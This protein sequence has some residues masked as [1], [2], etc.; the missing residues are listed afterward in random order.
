MI[1]YVR[2]YRRLEQALA[3]IEESATVHERLS[4]I[5]N[6]IVDGPGPDLGI[7]G[8]RLYRLDEVRQAVVLIASAGPQAI[9]PGFA[10]PAHYEPIKRLLEG[11]GFLLME[12]DDPGFDTN[13]EAQVGVERFAAIAVGEARTHIIAFTLSGAMD[14]ERALYLLATIRHVIDLRL[15]QS[16]MLRDIEETRRIQMSLLPDR[17]PSFHDFD[18]AARSLPAERVGGDLYDFIRQGEHVLGVAI[19]DSTGH[20][21]PAALM[22]RD[23]ITGLRVALDLSYRLTRGIEKVNRV[24]ARSA[25]ASRFISLLYVEFEPTGNI[26]YCNAGHPPGLLWR[27]TR[28]RRLSLGGPV[29]GPVPNTEYQRGFERFPPGSVLALYTDGITE[30]HSRAGEPFGVERIESIVRAER[31]RPAAEIVERI[32]AAVDAHARGPRQD[33]QTVVIIKRPPRG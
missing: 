23:V 30:A 9:E 29:L 13:L 2:T 25:L 32:F 16:H 5:V 18:I 4:G 11:E 28:L 14:P 33:D 27:G 17:P 8:C 12:K 31:D 24:V 6:A 19:G 21:L 20:G 7:T 15:E 22:A 26:V 3:S 10:V 1:D